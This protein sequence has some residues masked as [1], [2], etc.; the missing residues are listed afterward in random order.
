MK[1]QH[2]AAQPK[3]GRRNCALTEG[4]VRSGEKAAR[5]IIERLEGEQ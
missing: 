1:A 4:G 2:L 3:D 5:H